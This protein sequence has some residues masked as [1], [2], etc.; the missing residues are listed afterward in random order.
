MTTKDLFQ[1]SLIFIIVLWPVWVLALV[2][3]RLFVIKIA[4]I[5]RG[6]K[7]E[8]GMPEMALPAKPLGKIVP[9]H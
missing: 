4:S 3:I 5:V 2:F 7:T 1:Y 6:L 9:R 8:N